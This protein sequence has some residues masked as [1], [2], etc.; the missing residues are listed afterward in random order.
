[1]KAASLLPASRLLSS[2]NWGHT[3]YGS[4]ACV[5]RAVDAYLVRGTVPARGA[6]CVGDVQPFRSLT[7][8]TQGSALAPRAV[9]RQP[10]PSP[11]VRPLVHQR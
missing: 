1:M 5:N 3:A 4:S 6:R 11:V 2:D 8:S 10:A 9:G 7:P